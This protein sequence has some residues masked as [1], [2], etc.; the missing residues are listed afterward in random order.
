MEF[1]GS[2]VKNEGLDAEE[3]I[4]YMGGGLSLVEPQG[5][6]SFAI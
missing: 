5:E 4:Q 6:Y 3:M 1:A 2:D